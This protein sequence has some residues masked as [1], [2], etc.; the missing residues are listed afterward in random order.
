M[1]YKRKRSSTYTNKKRRHNVQTGEAVRTA[2]LSNGVY[3]NVPQTAAIH[4]RTYRG[5]YKRKSKGL[6]RA[7]RGSVGTKPATITTSQIMHYKVKPNQK[8]IVELLSNKCTIMDPFSNT[9][10]NELG[11]GYQIPDVNDNTPTVC[12]RYNTYELMTGDTSTEPVLASHRT[13]WCM[14]NNYEWKDNLCYLLGMYTNTMMP[15]AGGSTQPTVA[16]PFPDVNNP[17]TGISYATTGYTTG[18]NGTAMWGYAP[19]GTMRLTNGTISSYCPYGYPVPQ[20]GSSNAITH[21]EDNTH[22][23][24]WSNQS[25]YVLSESI[26]WYVH[27]QGT[28][29]LTVILN[30]C[31]LKYDIPIINKEMILADNNLTPGTVAMGGMISPVEVWKNSNNRQSF[32]DKQNIELPNTRQ[33]GDTRD[34]WQ[35]ISPNKERLNYDIT[36]IASST[37]YADRLN[38]VYNVKKHFQAIR[39]GQTAHFKVKIDYNTRISPHLMTNMYAIGGKSKTFFFEM[40]TRPVASGNGTNINAAT[41]TASVITGQGIGR[42]P[43]DVAIKWTKSKRFILEQRV[44]NNNLNIRCARP[45]FNYYGIIEPDG[46]RKVVGTTNDDGDEVEAEDINPDFINEVSGAMG[47]VFD[48]NIGDVTIF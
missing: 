10:G 32:G 43:A 33:S 27:N 18:A 42:P 39:P 48:I 26:T 12:D 3:G 15:G 11:G 29:D 38:S 19:P 34:Y 44:T 23:W 17:E 47:G 25:H 14:F 28:T 41:G 9:S 7:Q 20:I 37:K 16:N 30:E 13:D 4:Q 36:D 21:S 35:G 31:T 24:G 8:G 45:R 6:K 1:A 5:R 22:Q 46:D 40:L 2:I